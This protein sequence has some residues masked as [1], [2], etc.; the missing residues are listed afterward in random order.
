MEPTHGKNQIGIEKFN[1]ELTKWDW[2]HVFPQL[3]NSHWFNLYKNYT[4]VDALCYES[5]KQS[6]YIH[7]DIHFA[8]FMPG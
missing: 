1:L 7:T 4:S 5:I 3:N 6:L 2:T 8:K